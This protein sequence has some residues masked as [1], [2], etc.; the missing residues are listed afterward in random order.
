[1]DNVVTAYRENNPQL[2]YN[3]AISNEGFDPLFL[4]LGQGLRT[5]GYKPLCTQYVS[6]NHANR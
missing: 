3:V 5:K 2:D 6:L 1:M 4:K